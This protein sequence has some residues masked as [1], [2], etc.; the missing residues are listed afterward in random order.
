MVSASLLLHLSVNR[1]SGLCFSALL[2]CLQFSASV[3]L[4][5]LLTCLL[6]ALLVSA[7]PITADR[8]VSRSPGFCFSALLLTRTCLLAVPLVSASLVY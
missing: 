3:L 7:S 1:C 8:S 5:V 6:A 4:C 2:V